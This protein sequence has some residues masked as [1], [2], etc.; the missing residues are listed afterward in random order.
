MTRKTLTNCA[1]FQGEVFPI[2][3]RTEAP[4]PVPPM[5]DDPDTSRM[6]NILIT[7]YLLETAGYVYYKVGFLQYNFTQDDVSTRGGGHILIGILST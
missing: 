3:K 4:F 6:L 2:G 1:H 7:Q 5:P